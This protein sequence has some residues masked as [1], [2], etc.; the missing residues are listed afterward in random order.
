MLKRKHYVI[1]IL[2]MVLIG[3][4]LWQLPIIEWSDQADA[5]ISTHYWFGVIL[6]I[7]A[8][9]IWSLFVPTAVPIILAGYFFGFWV[10]TLATYVATTASFLVAFASTRYLFRDRVFNYLSQRPRARAFIDHLESAGWRL[11]VWMRISPIIPFHIQ[12]Y[13]YGASGMSLWTCLWSTLIGKGPGISVT[14][15]L[16]V[17]VKESSLGMRGID[18]IERPWWWYA[19]LILA[20][21]AA[22]AVTWLMMR[23][24]RRAM[25]VQEGLVDEENVEQLKQ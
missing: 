10:G 17:V 18:Q 21:I 23:S 3:I 22:C 11:V 6:F 19:F 12:N 20:S 14:V 4:A 1:G 13:C 2:L 8:L 9:F 15:L 25:R 5:W 16:G 7:I 24:A